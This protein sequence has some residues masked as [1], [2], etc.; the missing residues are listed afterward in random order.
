[1]AVKGEIVHLQW[2][3][4]PLAPIYIVILLILKIRKIKVAITVHNV[5]PHEKAFFNTVVSRSV[6][7]FGNVFIVHSRENIATLSR[8]ID[9]EREKN[10]SRAYGSARYVRWKRG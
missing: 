6:L 10:M 4:L 9:V 5:I 2:W 1:M 3:S 8:L 7:A